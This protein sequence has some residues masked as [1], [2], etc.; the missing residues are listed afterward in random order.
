LFGCKEFAVVDQC[1][2]VDCGERDFQHA[3]T[4][5]A[6]IG[7]LVKDSAIFKVFDCFVNEARDNEGEEQDDGEDGNEDATS[8]RSA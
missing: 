4:E 6:Y 3:I 2:F 7:G 5:R 1:D 8:L